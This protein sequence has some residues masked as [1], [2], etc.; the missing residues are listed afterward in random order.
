MNFQIIA[1]ILCGLCTSFASPA[2]KKLRKAI[3][4]SKGA[5]KIHD[6]EAFVN[7]NTKELVQR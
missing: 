4:V 6:R 2:V 1:D 3:L 7:G 5:E